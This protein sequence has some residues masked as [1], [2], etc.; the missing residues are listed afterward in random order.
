MGRLR[1]Q[2]D[3]VDDALLRAVENRGDELDVEK[4]D[5]RL[6]EITGMFDSVLPNQPV[7][8]INGLV[9]GLA[10]TCQA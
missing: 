8:R 9:R 7:V 6:S 2:F 10:C 5:Q 3:Y 1:Q 4:Y